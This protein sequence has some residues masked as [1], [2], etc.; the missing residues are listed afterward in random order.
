MIRKRLEFQNKSATLKGHDHTPGIGYGWGHLPSRYHGAV[1][2]SEYIVYSYD[3]PIAWFGP[4]PLITVESVEAFLAGPGLDQIEAFLAGEG[5]APRNTFPLSEPHWQVPA[6]RYSR[7]T[8]VHHM[9]AVQDALA[10]KKTWREAKD[11][12]SVPAPHYAQTEYART[13]YDKFA[14]CEASTGGVNW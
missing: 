6:V 5:A 8:S 13:P 4:E 9:G 12:K 3:T 10:Y 11:G 14:R 7:T 2:R 1:L